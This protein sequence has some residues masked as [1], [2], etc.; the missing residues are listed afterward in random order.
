MR[1]KA[2]NTD[3]RAAAKA[4]YGSLPLPEGGE[5]AVPASGDVSRPQHGGAYVEALLWVP[6]E[7]AVAEQRLREQ[8]EEK[9]K[10]A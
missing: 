7:R 1:S 9:E 4:M 3:F 2:K 8:Q 6:E 5:L 10:G